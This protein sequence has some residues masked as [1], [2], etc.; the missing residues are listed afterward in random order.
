VDDSTKRAL[1]AYVSAR[2]LNAVISVFKGSSVQAQPAGVGA[3]IAIGEAL[4]PLDDFIER[5]SWI[6]RISLTSLGI[7][8][9]CRKRQG[10]FDRKE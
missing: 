8:A 4:D 9:S 6:M 10:I 3:T 7:E 1:L 2:A 5:F